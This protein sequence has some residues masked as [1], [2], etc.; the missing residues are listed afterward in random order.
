MQWC[1][2]LERFTM[3][4]TTHLMRLAEEASRKLD[5]AYVRLEEAQD[6]VELV[7]TELSEQS[8]KSSY[9]E[10]RG[11]NTSGVEVDRGTFSVR[12]RG[13][14][15]VIGPTVSFYFMEAISRRPNRFYTYEQLIEAVWEGEPVAEATIRGAARDLRHRLKADGMPDLAKAVRGKMKMYGLITEAVS[16]Y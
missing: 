9:A 13:A 16:D 11:P 4:N 14:A 8:E 10:Q 7:L 15:S 5:L 6:L 3:R 12:W 2:Y 1:D